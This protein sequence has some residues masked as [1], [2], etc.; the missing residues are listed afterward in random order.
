MVSIPIIF[1][2]R[3]TVN[4]IFYVG[5]RQRSETFLNAGLDVNT[6]DIRKTV[7]LAEWRMAAVTGR[8]GSVMIHPVVGDAL[9]VTSIDDIIYKDKKL[10]RIWPNP[11]S[12]Y[13]TI[14]AGDLMFT[15][16]AYVTIMDLNGRELRKT[17]L[18]ERIDISSLP[19]GIYI[20]ITSLNGKPAGYGRL[21]KIK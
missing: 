2:I 5:W 18:S 14:D 16:D 11:A 4:D 13:I 19:A 12:E 8:T 1:L 7:L 20:I 21:I 3:Y 15:G 10:T 6:P 9:K 17:V